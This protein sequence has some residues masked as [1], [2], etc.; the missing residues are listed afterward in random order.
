MR[1]TESLVIPGTPSQIVEA[2]LSQELADA[3]AKAV[4]ISSVK[5]SVSGDSARTEIAVPASKLPSQAQRFI[6]SGVSVVITAKASGTTVHYTTDTSGAPVKLSWEISLSPAAPS[7]ELS[8]GTPTENGEAT[9]YDVKAELSVSIPFVGKKVESMAAGHARAL[10]VRD[11]ALV[12]DA[13]K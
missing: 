8:A 10:L 11:C 7:A 3:R 4:G 6:K 9:V 2:L 1:I 5:H 12:A 13:V